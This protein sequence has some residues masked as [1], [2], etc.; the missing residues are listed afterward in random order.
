MIIKDRSLFQYNSGDLVHIIPLLN[1]QL[2]TASRKVTIKYVG[3]VI[4]YKIIHPH[5]YLLMM[6]DGK[7]SRG[8]FEHERSRPANIRMIQGN[9]CNLVELKQVIN[10]GMK[11]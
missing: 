9:I 3:P 10:I 8:S 7:I 11:I 2:C 4:I 6:L 1:G 5:N